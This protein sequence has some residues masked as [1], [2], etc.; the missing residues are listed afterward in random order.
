MQLFITLAQEKSCKSCSCQGFSR[1]EGEVTE[2]GL[3]FLYGEVRGDPFKFQD[4]CQQ[5]GGKAA[6][7]QGTRV[8]PG[9]AL[10][11]ISSES[12]GRDWLG[13]SE[14]QHTRRLEVSCGYQP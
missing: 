1:L 13:E 12:L 3:F 7:W 8:L 10:Q 14:G 5:T 11:A 4:F 6:A 9:A 2:K